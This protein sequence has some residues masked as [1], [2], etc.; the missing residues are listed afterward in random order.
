VTI[1]LIIPGKP[2]G[3]GRPRATR[4][5]RVYTPAGTVQAEGDVRA[6]WYAAGCPKIEGRVPIKVLA[7]AA[8]RRPQAHWKTDGSMSK[9]GQRLP[10]PL[11]RVDVD[12]LLKLQLDSLSGC[13]YEDDALVVDGRAVKRW[14]A[15]M[16]REHVR[17]ELSEVTA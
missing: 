8:L 1:T 12:N 15:P 7:V 11:G 17:L 3:K 9:A 5:G 4:Q 14:A 10:N 16:E 6:A 2:T 13:A